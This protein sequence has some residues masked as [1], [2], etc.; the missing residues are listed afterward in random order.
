M[1]MESWF[2]PGL[3]WCCGTSAPACHA[4]P[5]SMSLRRIAVLRLAATRTVGR[6]R[7]P[8]S[9]VAGATRITACGPPEGT[10]RVGPA[11]SPGICAATVLGTT[12]VGTTRVGT[13]SPDVAGAHLRC[14][15][16]EADMQTSP[17]CCR[18]RS[19]GGAASPCTSGCAHAFG[20]QAS[21]GQSSSRTRR[22]ARH[23][24]S[25]P[26]PGRPRAVCTKSGRSSPR[27]WSAW[28]CTPRCFWSTIGG[29]S[30]R[31]RGSCGSTSPS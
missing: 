25:W 2:G 29:A 17:H 23:P 5:A 13:V 14:P 9:D 24:C 21:G 7:S 15:P 27:S 6:A 18:L 11:T 10:R 31:P 16:P 19:R 3:T 30:R 1:V 4:S 20:G 26:R 12:S 8:R 22:S 28:R